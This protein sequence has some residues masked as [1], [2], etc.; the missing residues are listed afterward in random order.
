MCLYLLF[1]LD[2][3]LA[4]SCQFVKQMITQ[5]DECLRLDFECGLVEKSVVFVN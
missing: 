3:L 2:L 4:L 5:L 1:D